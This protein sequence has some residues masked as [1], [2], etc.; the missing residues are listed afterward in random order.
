MSYV[1][2]IKKRSGELN[3]IDITK[4]RKMSDEAVDGLSGV[5]HSELE[6]DA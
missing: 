4:I 1:I 6:L 2:N 3:P 5:S